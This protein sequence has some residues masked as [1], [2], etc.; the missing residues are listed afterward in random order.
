[1][2]IDPQMRSVIARINSSGS[3]PFYTVGA[4]EARRLYKEAR[5]FL[6]PPVPE[7]GAV[8][9]L[10]AGGPAGPIPLRSLIHI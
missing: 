7:V 2:A 9:D 6:S 3:P 5:A 1:M 8:R 10:A 4:I